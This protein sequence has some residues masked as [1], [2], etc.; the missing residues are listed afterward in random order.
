MMG[1]DIHIY[2]SGDNPTSD[3]LR[4][5][6]PNWKAEECS[7]ATALIVVRV[8]TF[9]VAGCCIWI[10]D[11]F[12][13]INNRR[14]GRI[15]CFAADG[16]EHAHCA[17]SYACE[18]LKKHGAQMAVGPL[19]GTTWRSY[20]FVTSHSDEPPF[21][22]EPTNPPELPRW[23]FEAGFS[24]LATY[25]SA[26][27]PDLGV[28]DPRLGRTRARLQDEGVVIR[29][30]HSDDFRGDLQRIYQISLECFSSN[31]L[32]TPTVWESFAALY[33]RIRP[34]VIPELVRIAEINNDPV[35]YVFAIPNLVDAQSARECV[36]VKT[37]AVLP[38]RRTAGLG[39]VLV[40]DIH[41]TA[42]RLGFTRAIHALMHQSNNSLNLSGRYGKAFRE[43][44]ILS[45]PI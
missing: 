2:C 25:F 34:H 21:F 22:L 42:R 10:T 13:Q 7:D 40:A 14:V 44:Q 41:Q 37:V 5:A 28:E 39:N 12:P 16:A 45:R 29:A 11:E 31:F 26:S 8:G 35:G 15:G 36:I 33:E 32:Y 4:V 9:P 6:F 38:G 19:N 30:L 17:L 43:Y 18:E 24:T 27:V 23:W 3:E 20:R 1:A